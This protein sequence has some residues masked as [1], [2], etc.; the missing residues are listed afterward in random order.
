MGAE[1]ATRDIKRPPI[2][3]DARW[4]AGARQIENWLTV[5]HHPGDGQCHPARSDAPLTA[6]TQ[7]KCVNRLG[8]V[9]RGQRSQSARGLALCELPC[10]WI[11]CSWL[12]PEKEENAF[13]QSQKSALPVLRNAHHTIIFLVVSNLVHN[14]RSFHAD[15]ASSKAA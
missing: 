9:V 10:E 14:S 4:G 3:R 2:C 5:F 1:A 15:S 13:E 11:G 8:L 12:G 7:A 6:S